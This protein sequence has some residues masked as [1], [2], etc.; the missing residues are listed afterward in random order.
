VLIRKVSVFLHATFHTQDR[1]VQL[2]KHSGRKQ[3]DHLKSENVK[4]ETEVKEKVNR[5]NENRK[6]R[7]KNLLTWKSQKTKDFS[8]K[9][10]NYEKWIKQICKRNLCNIYN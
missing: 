8:F 7:K 9:I 10:K 3:A 5:V 1:C 2:N 4:V 6:S